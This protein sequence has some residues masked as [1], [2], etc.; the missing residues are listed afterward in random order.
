MKF[1]SNIKDKVLAFANN[2]VV[3]TIWNKLKH[4]HKVGLELQ[5]DYPP[6]VKRF[7][8]QHGD[9]PITSLKVFRQP[10]KSFIN[11]FLNIISLGKWDSVRKANG[12]DTFFHLG[13]VINNN[14]KLEKNQTISL[15]HDSQ[16]PDAEFL[17]IRHPNITIKELVTN[18]VNKVGS[19][20]FVY[21]AFTNNCQIFAM[22]VLKS[23]NLL[24]PE[25]QKF[26]VQPVDEVVK[27]LPEYIPKL[28][29]AITDTAAIGDLVT[30]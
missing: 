20:V 9:T 30:Q 27:Q 25:A 7:L 17:P 22:N 24:T 26:I 29:R 18:T 10:I 5:K 21:D 12:Y 19:S 11:K 23:N 2:G 15:N 14:I 6:S 16:Y 4:V 28:A 3:K 8:E 13:L 1:F